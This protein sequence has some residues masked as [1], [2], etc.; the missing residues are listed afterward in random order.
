MPY[1]SAVL[2]EICRYSPELQLGRRDLVGGA[3]RLGGFPVVPARFQRQHVGLGDVGLAGELLAD[4]RLA[5]LEFA[6]VHPRQQPEG[7]HVL[8]ALAVLLRSTDRLDRTQ[9]QRRHRDGLHDVVGQLVVFE[10]VGLVADLREVP[11][12]EFVGVG[13]DQATA[14]Q[15]GNVGLQR[16]GVHRDEDVGTVAGGEDVVV[17]DLDLERRNTGQGALWRTDLGG[18]IRLRRKVI[19]EERGLGG[20]PVTGELHTVTGVAREADD[21]LLQLLPRLRTGPVAVRT[22]DPCLSQLFGDVFFS[23]GRATRRRLTS[24]RV[25]MSLAVPIIALLLGEPSPLR[26][27]DTRVTFNRM[28]CSVR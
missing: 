23:R 12:G 8:G 14:G 3:E 1:A 6:A 26:P 24:T 9:R 4:E 11:F 28:R 25:L 13:D 15:I 22:H 19:A 27:R 17:G 16:G 7:E 2:P 20:E 18:V 5:V 21:D 10:R